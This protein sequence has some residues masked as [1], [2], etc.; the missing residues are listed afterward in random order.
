MLAEVRRP[1]PGRLRRGGSTLTCQLVDASGQ[2]TAVWFNARPWQLRDLA[3]GK[4][5]FFTGTVK[6]AKAGGRVVF[7]PEYEA[8]GEGDEADL[9]AAALRPRGAALP[10]SGHP[11]ALRTLVGRGAR[12]VAAPAGRSLARQRPHRERPGQPRARASRAPLSRGGGDHRRAGARRHRGASAAGVRRVPLDLA[13]PRAPPTRHAQRGGLPTAGGGDRARKSHQGAALRA[14]RGPATRAGRDRP[15]PLRVPPHAAAARGRRGQ[16]QDRGVLR[17]RC[18]SPS[19][20]GCRARSWPRPSCSPSSTTRPLRKML[21]PAGVTVHLVTGL[22]G[23]REGRG[24]RIA[25]GVPC[26]VVGTHALIQG[27]LAVRQAGAGRGRRTA[28]LR[29]ARSPE[30]AGEGARAARAAHVRDAHPAD[31]GAGVPRR[32]RRLGARRAAARAGGRWRPS[33]TPGSPAPRRW[34]RCTQRSPPA[35]QA[36]VVY[37]LVS[38]SEKLDLANATD[39]ARQAAGRLA[40]CAHGAGARPAPDGGARANHGGVPRRSNRRAG[41]DHRHRGGR[42][43]AERDAGHRVPGG[44]LRPLAAPPAARPGGARRARLAVPAARA[45]A[46]LPRRAATPQGAR[47]QPRRLPHRRGRSE[48]A[49]PRRGARARASRACPSSPSPTPSASGSCWTSA[50]KL[51]FDLVERDP[52]LASPE[53]GA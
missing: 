49:G 7:N 10:G 40:G 32:P 2:L 3:E 16:R 48:D 22:D 21:E 38:E 52:D 30:A 9:A 47:R 53:A 41:R 36:Y 6:L 4:R 19:R 8:A 1:R 42:G 31:A 25:Q 46:A 24:G 15:R 26:V 11:R 28:P 35:S 12:R 23:R 43:R 5:F 51:A 13:R 44:A 29:R 27:E 18:G 14:H 20:A 37:P 17:W 39:G 34:T 45:R 50:R 33:S